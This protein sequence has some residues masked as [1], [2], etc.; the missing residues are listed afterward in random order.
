MLLENV[1]YPQDNRVR[2]EASALTEA[3]Y[4]VTVIAPAAPGQPWHEVVDGVDTY[5]YPA[6]AA[7]NSAFGFIWEY[8]CSF[9]ASFMLSVV[10]FLRHG[11]DVVHAHNPPDL[12]VFI[13]AFYKLFGARFVFDHH[14]LSPEMYAARFGAK[15]SKVVYRVLVWLEK[16]SC[17]MADHVIATNES[18]KAIEAKRGGVPLDRITIVRN[19]PN[20]NRTRIVAPDPGLRNLGKTV[21]GYVGVMGYQDG[22][23]F[24]LRALRHLAYDL[25]RTD[26]MCVLI[27]SGHAWTS[28][29]ALA[30][31][32]RLDRYVWFTGVV[33]EE[34]LL[35]YLC[36]AD[37]CVD[38]DPSNPFN[39][40]SSMIKMS[41]YMALA[42]PIVAFDLPEHRVTA[43]EAACYVQPND[44]LEFARALARLM[45]DPERRQVMGAFGRQRVES[46]LAWPYSVPRLLEAY[47]SLF[48]DR[49]PAPA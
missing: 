35:R 5:R 6:P 36:A 16:L 41:E 32:L 17:R 39:D 33:S 1:P 18:Y 12:F 3:G 4:H 19:G 9:V 29:K 8:G 43:R 47:R 44:E 26:F 20:L 46:A 34:D 49:A 10:V 22:V 40:R 31:E 13:A 37:I 24:L 38:P 42:K 11:F 45:D 25:R 21:I 28:L 15:S 30:T 7:L 2:P 14:D 48:A 27:G 23:D